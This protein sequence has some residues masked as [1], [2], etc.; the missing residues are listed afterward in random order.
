MRQLKG[1][2][3]TQWAYLARLGISASHQVYG[4]AKLFST[5]LL[6]DYKQQILA[7]FTQLKLLSEH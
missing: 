4:W 5:L 7:L 2:P 1:I 3:K 6:Q